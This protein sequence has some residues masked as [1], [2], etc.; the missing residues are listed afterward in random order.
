VCHFCVAGRTS[1]SDPERETTPAGRRVTNQ[2][3]RGAG[4]AEERDWSVEGCEEPGDDGGDRG[5]GGGY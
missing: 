5:G 2:R 1:R 3:Y 4:C